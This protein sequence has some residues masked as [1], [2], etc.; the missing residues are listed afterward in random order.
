MANA[1]AD[2]GPA[3]ESSAET[4]PS[5]PDAAPAPD[6]AAT[7]KRRRRSPRPAGERKKAAQT[8]QPTP[9]GESSA[10]TEEGEPGPEATTTGEDERSPEGEFTSEIEPVSGADLNPESAARTPTEPESEAAHEE[11]LAPE[12]APAFEAKPEMVNPPEAEAEPTANAETEPV[13]DSEAKPNVDP[14]PEVAA[15]AEPEP[16]DAAGA[17]PEPSGEPEPELEPEAASEPKPKRRRPARRK[18]APPPVHFRVVR[19]KFAQAVSWVARCLPQS[20]MVPAL[21]GIRLDL[22]GGKLKL[23]AY[24][25]ESSAEVTIDVAAERPAELLLPGQ[26]LAEIT[27]ALADYEVYGSIDGAKVSLSCGDAH[28]TLTSM[29]VEDYPDLPEMPAPTGRVSGHFFAAAVGQ[30]VVAV[31]KDETLAMLTGMR[32]EIEGDSVT[33]AATDRFRLA[34]SQL[35]WRAA[36][37]DV[38][39]ALVVPGRLLASAAKSFAAVDD[40]EIGVTLDAEHGGQ[41]LGMSGGGRRTTV[42]LLDPE[43]PE[44]RNFVPTEFLHEADLN[45]EQ[46]LAAVKRVALVVN[47]GSS[48]RLNFHKDNSLMVV[49]DD[50]DS[51]AFEKLPVGWSKDT[52]SIGFNYELLVEGLS[53]IKCPVTR[54]RMTNSTSP[55]VLV[56]VVPEEK[57]GEYPEEAMDRYIHLIMPMR[58][59]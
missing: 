39:T 2:V 40:V 18:D 55:A 23:S 35:T 31:G 8:E 33:M 43:Y 36:A 37:P 29:P 5:A 11:E 44:Y 50:G 7:P 54:F 9:E 17:E 53:A 28:F 59:A 13:P 56:G 19:E 21:A 41:M 47:R 32:L 22:A 30:T 38:A 16:E 12:G 14:E 51:H 4:A 27:K 52:F 15:G 3:E 42:R 49:A 46:L 57:D 24:D 1:P 25:Y 26:L 34:V 58:L 10:P 45:T 48:V 20:P 6:G